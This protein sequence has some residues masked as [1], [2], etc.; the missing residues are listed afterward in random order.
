MLAE[1]RLGLFIARASKTGSKI[2]GE[3]S[4]NAKRKSVED[5]N[6]VSTSSAI[7]SS[8]AGVT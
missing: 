2:E 7:K 3:S 5:K 8:S 4:R 6:I 1:L